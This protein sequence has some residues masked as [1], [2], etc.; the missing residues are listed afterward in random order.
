MTTQ[1]NAPPPWSEHD[2]E[3][4]QE[5]FDAM[6]APLQPLDVTMLDGYLCGVLLQPQRVPASR[7]LPPILDTEQNGLPP[8]VPDPELRALIE[9]RHAELDLAIEHRQWFDPWIY[10]LDDDATPSEAV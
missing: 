6:P 4:L 7:W 5:L 9:R 3:R 8:G 10:E 1:P 2:L